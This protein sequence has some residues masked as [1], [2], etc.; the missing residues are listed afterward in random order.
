MFISESSDEDPAST[1]DS[2]NEDIE[3]VDLYGPPFDKK[4]VGDVFGGGFRSYKRIGSVLGRGFALGKRQESNNALKES[5]KD[6]PEKPYEYDLRPKKDSTNPQDENYA[7]IEDQLLDSAEKAK[8]LFGHRLG[9]GFALRKRNKRSVNDD[10][11]DRYMNVQ[12]DLKDFTNHIDDWDAKRYFAS[13]MGSRFGRRAHDSEIAAPVG[14]SR[15]SGFPELR[16][17][18]NKRY[19]D[20]D[21]GYRF[22]FGKR[23][24]WKRYFGHVLGNGFRLGKRNGEEND[25]TDYM[26]IMGNLKNEYDKQSGEVDDPFP[27][28]YEDEDALYLMAPIEVAPNGYDLSDNSY[29][30]DGPQIDKRFGYVLGRGFRFGKR[31]AKRYGWVLGNGYMYG[32]RSPVGDKYN[33][34]ESVAKMLKTVDANED[35]QKRFGLHNYYGRNIKRLGH[36]LGH[37]FSLGKREDDV[38]HFDIPSKREYYYTH[39]KRRPFGHVLGNGFAFGKRTPDDKY[40]AYEGDGDSEENLDAEKRAFGHWLGHGFKLGKRSKEYPDDEYKMQDH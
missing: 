28:K 17:Y 15:D 14:D 23:S 18:Q 36:L 29:N 6:I 5:L 35:M 21:L 11:I 38:N 2:V 31:P 4:W 3:E 13:D 8:R 30:L 24:G 22:A 33:L 20:S 25:L 27:E 7:N 40:T 16:D 10:D 1:E 37:G 39:F 34:E 32:K 9:N 26:Y 12:P 19:F